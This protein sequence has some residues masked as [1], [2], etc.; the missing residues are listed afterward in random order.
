MK[1]ISLKNVIQF[2]KFNLYTTRKQIFG[3]TIAIA[4]IMVMYMI[5]FPYVADMGEMKLET[6]PSEL[7]ELFGMSDE[8]VMTD[9]TTYFGMIY[10]LILVAVAIFAST[11]SAGLITRE[12]KTKSIEFLSTLSVSRLEI[13]VAKY[14]TSTLAVTCVLAVAVI[15]TI[16][17]GLFNGGETFDLMDIMLSAKTTSFTALFF[18]AIAL[19]FAA[20]SPKTGGG[21]IGSMIVL[22]SYMLGYLGQILGDKAEFLLNLSPFISFSVENSLAGGYDFWLT[23]AIYLLIYVVAIVA[24]GICYNKRDFQV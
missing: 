3:W 16:A 6:M 15:S 10:M 22:A 13:Y 11:F 14:F 9:Y 2:C 7:L 18:G 8:A 20:F 19:F 1:D 12:E 4:A 24:G 5:L 21:S 17:C 23:F